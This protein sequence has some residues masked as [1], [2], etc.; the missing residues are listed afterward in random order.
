MQQVITWLAGVNWL[1]VVRSLATLVTAAIA[2][3]ALKN[4]Q[5]QDKARREVEFLDALIEAVHTY[6]VELGRPI[7]LIE[8]TR[9]GMR[10]QTSSWEDEDQTGATAKGAVIFIKKDGERAAKRLF[11]ALNEVRPALIKVRSLGTKGQVFSFKKYVKCHKALAMLAWQFD[12]IQAFAGIV[13]SPTLNWDHPEVQHSLQ[14]V[15][16]V[17]EDDLRKH[18]AEN[19][20]I[21]L[22]FAREAYAR[23]YGVEEADPDARH[24]G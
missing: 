4:W 13:G 2:F 16:T 22:D 18:L 24:T 21:V 6:I 23:S 10:S 7:A 20:V 9:I 14:S 12:R 15:L 11:D 19:N 5:R 8:S 3:A 17:Q 1:E